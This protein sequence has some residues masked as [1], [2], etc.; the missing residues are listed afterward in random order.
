VRAAVLIAGN[1]VRENRWPVAI[2]LIWGLISG[3]AGVVLAGHSQED[4]L[5]FLKQQAMYSVFFTVFLASSALHNQRRTRRILA[6]LSKGIERYEYLG[7]I[8]LGYSAVGFV[9]ATSLGVTGVFTFQRAGADAW[10]LLPLLLML[11]IASVLAG[12]VA[13]FFSTFMPPLLAL[14]ATSM[15]LGTSAIVNGVLGHNAPAL[16]PFYQLISAVSEF[17]LQQ[18]SAMPWQASAWAVIEIFAFWAAASIVFARRDVAV[19]VE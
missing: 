13:L 6:V 19:P 2:L 4:A 12:T 8:A 9:Y 18:E 7:G 11:L 17:S 1:F 14:A 10:I 15:V 3:S 16:V 5:F